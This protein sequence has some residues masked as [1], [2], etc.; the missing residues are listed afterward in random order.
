MSPHLLLSVRYRV[1]NYSLD[2]SL[3]RNHD[4]LGDTAS[5]SASTSE[6]SRKLR[7]LLLR[8]PPAA[9]CEFLRRAVVAEERVGSALCAEPIPE[10]CEFVESKEKVLPMMGSSGSIFL[11]PSLIFPT[12]SDKDALLLRLPC[13][14]LLAVRRWPLLVRVRRVV[15]CCWKILSSSSS[16]KLYLR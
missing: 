6:P 15:C 3:L 1:P 5:A 10:L 14:P 2:S 16:P 11:F 13:V 12:S 8:L 9:R 7:L 4:F